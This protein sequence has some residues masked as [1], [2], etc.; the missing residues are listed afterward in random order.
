M[1]GEVQR[2]PAD[3]SVETFEAALLFLIDQSNEPQNVICAAVN[4]VKAEP[5]TPPP[6]QTALANICR[7]ATA[8]RG[9]GAIPN[10]RTGFGPSGFSAP[11]IST[12][13]GSSGYT[14]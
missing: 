9:T 6:A 4:V 7:Q 1:R 8:R 13:G 10:T 5:T 12:G 3:S 11:A 2:L 14:P